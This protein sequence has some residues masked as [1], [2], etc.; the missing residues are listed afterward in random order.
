MEISCGFI[1]RPTHVVPLLYFSRDFATTVFCVSVNFTLA[2]KSDM[3][4]EM[5]KGF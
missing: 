2:E 3:G 4:V 1:L 5:L